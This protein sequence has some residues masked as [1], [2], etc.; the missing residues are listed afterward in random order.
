MSPRILY[1]GKH[2]HSDRDGHLKQENVYL[3]LYKK[4]KEYSIQVG[5]FL[6]TFKEE[7]FCF[8]DVEEI[9]LSILEEKSK[10][11]K[12]FVCLG[13]KKEEEQA[14]EN[15]VCLTIV[16]YKDESADGLF[17]GSNR[18]KLFD[19]VVPG[20]SSQLKK[21]NI[22]LQ[23]TFGK[24]MKQ[25]FMYS[26]KNNNE[27]PVRVIL[28]KT[29]FSVLDNKLNVLN[30][31]QLR[32]LEFKEILVN[33]LKRLIKMEIV[34]K[35]PCAEI[36]HVHC[37]NLRSSMSGDDKGYD[38]RTH[39]CHQL[40]E[41]HLQ[42]LSVEMTNDPSPE[43][44]RWLTDQKTLS[45][46]SDLSEISSPCNIEWSSST[47]GI[48]L[49]PLPSPHHHQKSHE[50]VEN[51][52]DSS[53]ENFDDGKGSSISDKSSSFKVDSNSITV[54]DEETTNSEISKTN[55]PFTV[56]H[57]TW[58]DPSTTFPLPTPHDGTN[59]GAM[60]NSDGNTLVIVNQRDPVNPPSCNSRPPQGHLIRAESVDVLYP[61]KQDNDL[62][63]NDRP[64]RNS[65]S[66]DDSE[67]QRIYY[68]N[69][70]WVR[71][72]NN[73]VKILQ[74]FHRQ[75][76]LGLN[77]T[78]VDFEVVN[79]HEK[80]WDNEFKMCEEDDIFMRTTRSNVCHKTAVSE[81][82]YWNGDLCLTVQLLMERKSPKLSMDLDLSWSQLCAVIIHLSLDQTPACMKKDWRDF[83]EKLG[84]NC[85]DIEI[86]QY[87]C[88]TQ[89]EW[90]ARVVL[91]HWKLLS[92][93]YENA[94]AFNFYN[95]RNF[96]LELG[97]HDILK[98]VNY[99][100]TNCFERVYD[101]CSSNTKL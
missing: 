91:C 98:I 40:Q 5:P 29:N 2:Y 38:F 96:L 101:D 37:I 90:P 83:A 1:T 86:I 23:K 70:G 71:Y 18:I 58:D 11:S 26:V 34:E 48:N 99:S 22:K 73:R 30:Y 87:F 27:Q 6:R 45:G 62:C 55:G 15:F 94:R 72:S 56:G 88:Y 31:H 74:R 67:Y 76:H 85:R 65:C 54:S 50:A 33:P 42:E 60:E 79:K 12:P 89:R 9:E 41:I 4:E 100:E 13:H 14:Y 20:K 61:H 92:S 63:N 39:L 43:V 64:N 32:N 75:R 97:R 8:F 28:R 24:V 68:K 25:W 80:W 17:L 16:I 36:Q 93:K 7:E 49:P 10:K 66:S 77:I 69:L 3:R 78:D 59:I 21:L 19:R 47:S 81:T 46:G 51:S 35:S 84:L 82:E 44:L 95:L 52:D 53:E 57:K